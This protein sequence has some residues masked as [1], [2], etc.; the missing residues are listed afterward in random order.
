MNNIL[1]ICL[2][3][4]FI[5]ELA[6]SIS[7]E[8]GM[9]YLDIE[10]A[11]AYN[12]GKYDE[13]V[14]KC[15]IDYLN[16]QEKGVISSLSLYEDTLATISASSSITHDVFSI[17]KDNYKI[18]YIDLSKNLL[19]SLNNNYKIDE[20]NSINIL[21]YSDVKKYV[22]NKRIPII[23]IKSLRTARE[24]ILKGIKNEY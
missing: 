1:L 24:D 4:N 7:S 22:S 20:K 19:K 21:V 16:K 8:L 13:V 5:T 15:G 10:R 14:E 17:L 6:F 11:F 3:Y 2:D 12:I 18:F 23:S 9:Y